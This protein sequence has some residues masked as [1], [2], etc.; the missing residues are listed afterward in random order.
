M[1]EA[2]PRFTLFALL[3]L[4]G[5]EADAADPP[6]RTKAAA[7]ATAAEK[8]KAAPPGRSARAE[9]AKAK[10]AAAAPVPQVER[11]KSFA[12][13]PTKLWDGD[14]PIHCAEGPRIR[15]SGIAARET[16]G[17][18][19]PGHPC[20]SASAEKARDTLAGLL[21]RTTGTAP[22]G[23]L[24]IQGPALTCHA[25]GPAGGTRTA[26][27]CQSPTHGDLSCAMVASG[28][29]EKW[30]RYWGSHACA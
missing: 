28:T 17:S 3:L 30:T 19:S 2:R 26:A 21:G 22:Q 29:V 4:A 13:T 12:C 1:P 18:C 20:P 23:H 8:A 11:G 15:L 16:D 25:V 6:A 14:G 5:C 24:L 27:W 9:P 10:R 7:T